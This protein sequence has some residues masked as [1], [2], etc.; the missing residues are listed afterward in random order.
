VVSPCTPPKLNC[1]PDFN[2]GQGGVGWSC[3]P[4]L[5]DA[6]PPTDVVV[7]TVSCINVVDPFA[8]ADGA[9]LKVFDVDYSYLGGGSLVDLRDVNFA[10]ES[11][12]ELMSCNPEVT[13]A[14]DCYNTTFGDIQ[15]PTPTNTP[16]ATFTPCSGSACPTATSLAFVTV[17]P[18]PCPVGAAN[19]PTATPGVEPTTSG[20]A[21][22]AP[23]PP[24]PPAGGPPG[25]TTGGA[26]AGRIRPPD[27]GT[28][29]PGGDN[30][31]LLIALVAGGS[32]L[33]AA[34]IAS[35]LVFNARRRR[36]EDQS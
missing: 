21:T 24:P 25:G 10:D 30:T 36:E 18:T 32:A 12:T 17:T 29:P 6:W 35:G 3:D 7:S 16:T 31:G 8:L 14:G 27:T 1:N 2:E 9:S 34:G 20:E 33:G 13:L 11:G 5:A 15:T 4:V 28:G 22:I 26:G 19:C 23:P